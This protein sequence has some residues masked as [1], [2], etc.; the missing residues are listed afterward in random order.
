MLVVY[1]AC[2]YTCSVDNIAL[3]AY[4]TYFPH[5]YTYAYTYDNVGI[6]YLYY[7]VL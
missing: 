4:T 6:T 5:V 3:Q 2:T 7:S 1:T